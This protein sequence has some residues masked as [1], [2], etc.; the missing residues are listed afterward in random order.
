MNLQDRF[1]FEEAVVAALGKIIALSSHLSCESEV[2]D[3]VKQSFQAEYLGPA[4]KE[5][6]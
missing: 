5:F 6:H 2:T 1:A 4:A 3:A